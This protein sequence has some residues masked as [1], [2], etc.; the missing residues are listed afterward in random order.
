MS[1]NVPAKRACVRK[2]CIEANENIAISI[3]LLFIYI[4]N[5]VPIPFVL[6]AIKLEGAVKENAVI[7]HVRIKVIPL[8]SADADNTYN[9]NVLPDT[10]LM[11]MST[12]FNGLH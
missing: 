4:C 10:L 9:H 1:K 3:Q 11:T 2:R 7:W 12:N 8:L 6:K 5:Q